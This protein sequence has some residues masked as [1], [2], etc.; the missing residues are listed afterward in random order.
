LR[1]AVYFVPDPASAL[2]QFGCSAIGY[3]AKTGHE[4]ALSSVEG[5]AEDI[6]EQAT[7]EPRRY[8]FHGTLKPPFELAEGMSE[9]DLLEAVG[10]FASGQ[11]SFEI[12]ALKVAA[13]GRFVALVPTVP[14]PQ[15][16]ALAAACVEAFEPF[17][18][19]LSE[20]DR[21]RRLSK[22]LSERQRAY[23]DRWGYPYVFD[24]F[25]FH[26]TLTGPLGDALRNAFL[27]AHARHYAT[28]AEP[29]TV[30][31]VALCRQS[32]RESRFTVVQRFSFGS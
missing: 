31:A 11:N 8:G 20:R 12:A 32:S 21:A 30:N 9:A 2:W 22:P 28:I 29:L 25:R 17:R 3:D 14:N 7:A 24:E 1:Y 4:C 6:L 15:I 27:D 13:L 23:L 5:V 26:M 18:A 16:A 19:P 10:M